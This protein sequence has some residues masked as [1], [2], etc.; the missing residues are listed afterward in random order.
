MSPS[1]PRRSF[2]RAKGFANVG[3]ELE[4]VVLNVDTS[5]RKIALSIKSLQSAVDKAELECFM[6]SQ[7][8]ATSNL[9]EL[10]KEEQLKKNGENNGGHSV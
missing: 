2:R 7:K 9:G 1:F 4:A 8:E 6:G 10:L 5:D 3:D